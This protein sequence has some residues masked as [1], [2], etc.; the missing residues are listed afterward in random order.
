MDVADH[1]HCCRRSARREA[2]VYPEAGPMN[3]LPVHSYYHWRSR[4][5]GSWNSLVHPGVRRHGAD[6]R[7]LAYLG[8]STNLPCPVLRSEFV[9]QYTSIQQDSPLISGKSNNQAG[10]IRLPPKR[11]SLNGYFLSADIVRILGRI[12]NISGRMWGYRRADTCGG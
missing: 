1:Y 7:N 9:R 3:T 5:S 2:L 8:P 11:V 6:D 12:G 4:D 10:R